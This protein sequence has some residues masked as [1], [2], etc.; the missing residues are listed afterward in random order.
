MNGKQP[1]KLLVKRI[2]MAVAGMALAGM[3]VGFFKRAFLAWIPFSA[4]ATAFIR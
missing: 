1:D 4:S 2:I 3:A